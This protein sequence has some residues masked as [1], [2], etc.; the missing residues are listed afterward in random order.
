M[1]SP[2]KGRERPYPQRMQSRRG[3]LGRW[4]AVIAAFLIGAVVVAELSSASVRG[5]TSQRPFATSVAAAGL[6]LTL[7]VLGVDVL[8]RRREEAQWRRRV[9][10]V[11][12]AWIERAKVLVVVLHHF[13]RNDDPVL[14]EILHTH[15]RQAGFGAKVN[16]AFGPPQQRDFA[17]FKPALEEWLAETRSMLPLLASSPRA[18]DAVSELSSSFEACL[19]AFAFHGG[20]DTEEYLIDFLRDMHEL[21][22]RQLACVL[23][24]LGFELVSRAGSTGPPEAADGYS[25]CAPSSVAPAEYQRNGDSWPRDFSP[26]GEDLRAA[27][28]DDDIPF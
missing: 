1:R 6:I 18:F 8:L 16:L 14:A 21:A 10:T 15:Y 26:A 5:W 25:P 3:S 20:L 17:W 11:A 7:T 23:D 2:L 12:G 19:G 9:A 24:A 27:T 4:V 22:E 13:G 28:G